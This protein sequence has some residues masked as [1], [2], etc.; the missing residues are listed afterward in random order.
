MI[1]SQEYH[2]G[3]MSEDQPI[4]IETDADRQGSGDVMSDEISPAEAARLAEAVAGI[5]KIVP[6]AP[7][8]MLAPRLRTPLFAG[9]V[10]LALG[11]HTAGVAT[12]L[13]M[14]ASEGDGG[15]LTNALGT[16]VIEAEI[17]DGQDA[18]EK[19]GLT[20]T[21]MPGNTDPLAIAAVDQDA[22]QP[23]SSAAS[24][25]PTPPVPVAST[26]PETLATE[27]PDEMQVAALPPAPE[28]AKTPEKPVTAPIEVAVT[29]QPAEPTANRPDPL[30]ANTDPVPAQDASQASASG[31][32]G[33][34][35]SAIEKPGIGG[36]AGAT[37]GEIKTYQ[38][39][40]GARLRA[41]KPSGRGSRGFVE[42]AFA[43]EADGRLRFAEVKRSSGNAFLE[44]RALSAV[45]KASPFPKPPAQMSG[46]Q[47]EFSVPFT[48]E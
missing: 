20:E 3:P 2:F 38:A 4:S 32:G 22:S 41:N 9:F 1:P 37:P 33:T 11:A 47:L 45:R 14:R 6:F 28:P 48:F 46:K 44:D 36:R 27:K 29:D 5:A 39:R 8:D 7:K 40:L 30:P 34:A 18:A 15:R 16:V 19:G 21:A 17:V 10:V 35:Q 24:A 43:I 12:H 26:N 31:D 25:Q 13:L 42:I 23:Q